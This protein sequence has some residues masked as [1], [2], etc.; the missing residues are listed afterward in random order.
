MCNLESIKFKIEKFNEMK[1]KT[2]IQ[3]LHSLIW[4]CNRI[5]FQTNTSVFRSAQIFIFPFERRAVVVVVDVVVVVC[6]FDPDDANIALYSVSSQFSDAFSGFYLLSSAFIILF[7]F[8]FPFSFSFTSLLRF[9]LLVSLS[10]RSFYS[11]SIIFRC[12][13]YFWCIC[14]F[15]GWNNRPELLEFF[16]KWLLTKVIV[17]GKYQTMFHSCCS[18]FS[19]CIHMNLIERVILILECCLLTYQIVRTSVWCVFVSIFSVYGK[20]RSFHAEIITNNHYRIY[21]DAMSRT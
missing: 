19:C 10:H 7:P 11:A 9:F 16:H 17:I 5:H 3:P 14:C 4:N 12:S 6:F 2:T 20:Q 15:S 1:I 21:E 8:P 18:F 13:I